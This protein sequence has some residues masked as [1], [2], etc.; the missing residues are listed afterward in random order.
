[1]RRYLRWHDTNRLRAAG[2]R[3]RVRARRLRGRDRDGVGALQ[4][5]RCLRSSRPVFVRSVFLRRH[6]HRLRRDLRDRPRLCPRLRVPRRRLRHPARCRSGRGAS[7]FRG[8]RHRARGRR[9]GRRPPRGVRPLGREPPTG[10]RSQAACGW[11]A[12]EPRRPCA[13]GCG[14]RR[15]PARGRCGRRRGWTAKYRGRRKLRLPDASVVRDRAGA[16]VVAPR[17]WS[18][19]DWTPPSAGIRRRHEMSAKGRHAWSA[20]PALATRRT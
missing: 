18:S 7:R 16:G 2:D 1:M 17:C 12:A 3:R 11:C 19:L 6:G 15:Y 10:G 5:N 9:L 8:A 20:R 13:P 14:P 4:W